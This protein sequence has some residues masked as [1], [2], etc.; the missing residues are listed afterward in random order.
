MKRIPIT[1]HIPG[2]TD[3]TLLFT[4]AELSSLL[5]AAKRK[6]V[7]PS[8]GFMGVV[9]KVSE[10]WKDLQSATSRCVQAAKLAPEKIDFN[11]VAVTQMAITNILRESIKRG[12]NA[13]IQI[14]VAAGH[15]FA[16]EIGRAHKLYPRK[17]HAIA[18]TLPTIPANISLRTLADDSTRGR[19]T[20]LGYLKS[21]G[22]GKASFPPTA[23]KFVTGTIWTEHAQMLLREIIFLKESLAYTPTGDPFMDSLVA[24]IKARADK[25]R[26]ELEAL[27]YVA[28]D[29]LVPLWDFAKILL[30]DYWEVNPNKEAEAHSAVE[31]DLRRISKAENPPSFARGKIREAFAMLLQKHGQDKTS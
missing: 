20:M 29:A 3:V 10:D 28:P 15:A 23:T 21:T 6:G 19:S 1:L 31:K 14:T 4:K 30:R 12:E 16:E 18:S 17:L 2:E 7:D 11:A 24:P 13:G 25:R 9:Q 8:I 22:V 26:A 27:P 5:S